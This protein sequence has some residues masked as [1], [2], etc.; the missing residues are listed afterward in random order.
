MEL[1]DTAP[2]KRHDLRGRLT[3]RA[4]AFLAEAELEQAAERHVAPDW[5]LMSAAYFL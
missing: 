3:R 5:S 4:P 2:V 1:S